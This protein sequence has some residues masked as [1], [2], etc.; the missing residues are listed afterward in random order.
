MDDILKDERFA[1]IPNDPRFRRIP[2][3]EVKIKVDK[4]F[5]AMFKDKK[6]NIRYTVDKRGRPINQSSQ[7][8]FRKFYDYSSTEEDSDDSSQQ[9][10]HSKSKAKKSTDKNTCS[11]ESKVTKAETEENSADETCEE[12]KDEDEANF[13]SNGKLLLVKPSKDSDAE[14]HGDSD[15]EDKKVSTEDEDEDSKLANNELNSKL[16]KKSNKKL[17]ESIKQKLNDLNV[18]YARGEGVLFSESSSDDESSEEE[19]EEEIEHDWG[20]LDKDAESI[21]EPTY[22]LAACNMDWDRIKAVDIMVLFHSFVPPTGY[23]KNVTIYPSEFGLKRMKEEELKGPAELVESEDSSY[24]EEEEEKD[25]NSDG[26]KEEGSQYQ[27]EKLRKYQLNRL[28]YYYAVIVFDSP[29]T[30]NKIYEELDGQEYESSATKLDLRFIPDEETFDQEPTE[31]CDKLPDLTKYMPRLFT[32]TAL[33]Q[34]KVNLTWDETNPERQEFAQKLKSANLDEIDKNDLQAY[35]ASGTSDEESEDEVKKQLDKVDETSNKKDRLEMYKSLVKSIEEAEEKKKDKDVELEVTWGL[36]IKE[37]TEQLLK[38]KE[39]IKQQESLAP[40]E[41]YLQKRK[42]KIKAKREEKKKLARGDNKEASDSEDSIPS[43]IDMNDPYFA[44]EMKNMPKQKTK[45]SKS[46]TNDSD[47]DSVDE[48]EN[49]R[50]AAELEL[51][52]MDENEGGKKCHFDMKRIEEAET[53]TKSKKKRL[54]KRKK[55]LKE[56]A[57]KD[58][59][60]V[61]VDD[62]R[63]QK[64]FTSHLFNIDPTD[65]RYRKTKGTED[66]VKEK[67]KRRNETDA[68][69]EKNTFDETQAAPQKKQKVNTEINTLINSIKRNTKN[70]NKP[71][72]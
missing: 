23:I 66:L 62:P 11:D 30:A 14:I 28:K 32:T 46:R 29:A 45:K 61:N 56:E 8:N 35:L 37:K 54:N 43:D 59:F 70:M 63:F 55:D 52:L 19:E 50:K 17:D 15:A 5:R 4:R 57:I 25:I 27:R 53:L 67:L 26:E 33:Q 34:V 10:K 36:G 41:K 9:T 21:P 6:F 16:E 72:K 24:D 40:F 22:R 60:K 49:K 1:H 38:E 44:E 64:L 20:E 13:S 47:A 39:K 58:E 69:D 42:E 3:K 65:P 7:E 71:I 31:V 51:L 18:D 12:S 48:E 68:T 2:K